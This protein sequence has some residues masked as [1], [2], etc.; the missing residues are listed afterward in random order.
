MGKRVERYRQDQILS[1]VKGMLG[2]EIHLNTWDGQT[3]TGFVKE[4]NEKEIRIEDGN[5]AWYNRKK[6]SHSFKIS[7]ILEVIIDK[8]S[9]H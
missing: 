4:V 6:H 3:Y 5:S 1:N 2:Q 9:I 7:E 8:I